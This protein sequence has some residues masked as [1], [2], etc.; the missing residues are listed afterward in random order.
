ML[1][2]IPHA[3]VLP[4]NILLK[5]ILPGSRTGVGSW[6]LPVELP[7]CPALLDPQQYTFP[8]GDRPQV[9]YPRAITWVNSRAGVFVLAL[10]V[11]IAK[12]I[13]ALVAPCGGVADTLN[14]AQVVPTFIGE[15]GLVVDKTVSLEFSQVMVG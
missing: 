6:V 8:E 14:G 7:V 5:V 10:T 12:P 13:R 15:D 4:A 2:E 1:V 9:P 3:E 11:P